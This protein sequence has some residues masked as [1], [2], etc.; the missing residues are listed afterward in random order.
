MR[1]FALILRVALHANTILICWWELDTRRAKIR[2][3]QFFFLN[4]EKKDCSK[5]S[6]LRKYTFSTYSYRFSFW[7]IF[8]TNL[9]SVNVTCNKS[10]FLQ[11]H[12]QTNVSITNKRG[13]HDRIEYNKFQFDMPKET[14]IIVSRPSFPPSK[15]QGEN[16]WQYGKFVVQF[17]DNNEQSIQR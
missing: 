1:L 4:E 15:P 11:P 13:N 2:G 10:T 16:C 12:K 9:K 8:F 7:L 3:Y 14:C 6:P 17:D 5:S